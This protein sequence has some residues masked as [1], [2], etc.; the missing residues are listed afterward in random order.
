MERL[1][2]LGIGL[3]DFLGQFSIEEAYRVETEGKNVPKEPKKGAAKHTKAV[4][5]VEE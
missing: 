4:K 2:Q 3:E 5:V 1:V